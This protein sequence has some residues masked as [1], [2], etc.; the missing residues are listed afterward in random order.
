MLKP[1]RLALLYGY[2][3]AHGTRL[4]HP[5]GTHPVCSLAFAQ[6]MIEAGLLLQTDQRFELTPEGRRFAT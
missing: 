4:Y 1:L 3:I 2:L 6:Q 5:G